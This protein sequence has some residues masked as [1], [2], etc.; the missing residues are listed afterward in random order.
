LKS[1]AQRKHEGRQSGRAIPCLSLVGSSAA[2]IGLTGFRFLGFG[3]GIIV[4]DLNVVRP[5]MHAA[6]VSQ[7]AQIAPV[8]VLA[9][10]VARRMNVQGVSR[11]S[12]VSS[13]TPVVTGSS[14]PIQTPELR[15]IKR[16]KSWCAI[17]M[18]TRHCAS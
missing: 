17:A 5:V 8:V 12:D 16:C 4:P 11:H 10:C 14:D 13:T 18:S 7:F 9:L 2:M 1:M 15:P 3:S 6:A